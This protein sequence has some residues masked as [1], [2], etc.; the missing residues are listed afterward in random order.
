MNNK[1]VQLT[2]IPGIIALAALGLSLVIP[3]SA[4]VV[5]VGAFAVLALFGLASLEYR[6][7]PRRALGR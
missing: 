3:F 2:V 1:L 6:P 4:D 5:V 7:L